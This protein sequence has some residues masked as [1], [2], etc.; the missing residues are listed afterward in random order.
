MSHC[1]TKQLARETKKPF[2]D[3]AATLLQSTRGVMHHHWKLCWTGGAQAVQQAGW[4]ATPPAVQQAGCG[5]RPPA[6]QQ[7]GWAA[8]PP[9]DTSQALLYLGPPLKAVLGVHG[10]NC[11]KMETIGFFFFF[12]FY[13]SLGKLFKNLFF[14]KVP[15]V[16]LLQM[17]FSSR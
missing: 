5:A 8:T 13:I 17:V 16:L 10:S 1:M 9:A 3:L 6:V 15:Q 11:F 12:K 4:A 14:D 2:F 7:A